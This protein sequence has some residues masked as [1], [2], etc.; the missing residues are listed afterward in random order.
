MRVRVLLVGLVLGL[1]ALLPAVANAAAPTAGSVSPVSPS[2]SW[3]GGPLVTSNPSG[4]CFPVDPSCD[5]SSL[6]IV[7]PATGSYTVEIAI[8]PSAE[9]DDYD[10]VDATFAAQKARRAG[11]VPRPRA[12][13]RAGHER[14]AE[15]HERTS[16]TRS[17]GVEGPAPRRA[18]NAAE[19]LAIWAA[20]EGGDA[21]EPA[22][23]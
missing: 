22:T 13:P 17:R 21:S 5:T 4:L 2:S 9:G 8:A 16:R 7:P 6:T 19:E 1:T 14:A 15:G 20:C 10:F 12:R 3:S 18:L 11:R 23:T